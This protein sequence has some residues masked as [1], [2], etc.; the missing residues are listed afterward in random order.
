MT[1]NKNPLTRPFLVFYSRNL[2]IGE[3]KIRKKGL[4]KIIA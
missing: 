1:S 3:S 2:C 4:E